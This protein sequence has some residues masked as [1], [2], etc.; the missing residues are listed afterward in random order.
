VAVSYDV[1]GSTSRLTISG[2]SLK[3]IGM[4]PQGGA[5]PDD[6]TRN[7]IDQADVVIE[8]D[9][10]KTGAIEHVITGVKF[11]RR[12]FRIDQG[13]LAGTD[14]TWVGISNRDHSEL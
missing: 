3:S 4:F 7:A 8:V 14:I 12:S 13:N 10:T 9:D 2:E 1:S 11:S 5:T 6:R